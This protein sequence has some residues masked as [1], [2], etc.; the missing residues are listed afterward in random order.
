M[1]DKEPVDH[2]Q[3][4]CTDCNEHAGM[5]ERLNSGTGIMNDLKTEL[6]ALRKDFNDHI[7]TQTRRTIAILISVIL[8]L[9]S[10]L[11]SVYTTA[12]RTVHE[13]ESK[14]QYNRQLERS[15]L[16]KEIAKAIEATKTTP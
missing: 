1:T 10:V 8:T 3:R 2:L 15:T 16:A 12:L 9:V 11:G 6:V 7:K 13:R 14:T 4:R 5:V